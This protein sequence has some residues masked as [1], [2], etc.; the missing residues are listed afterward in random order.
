MHRTYQ[1]AAAC[2]LLSLLTGEH[3]EWQIPA[4]LY[5]AE[6]WYKNGA[7]QRQKLLIQR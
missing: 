6:A 4:G 7:T 1:P 5:I 2:A 3:C